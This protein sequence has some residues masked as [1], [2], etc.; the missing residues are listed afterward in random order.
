M[1]QRLPR[2]VTLAVC[3][4]ISLGCN[5]PATREGSKLAAAIGT[6]L[7]AGDAQQFGS[8]FADDA[9]LAA[10]EPTGTVLRGRKQIVAYYAANFP[11]SRMNLSLKQSELQVLGDG[12]AVQR[13]E[14]GGFIIRTADN[15]RIDTRG[16]YV[17][18]LNRRDDGSWALF[19]AIWGFQHPGSVGA[20]DDDGCKDCCCAT[21]S[22]CDCKA[23]E[24][25]T[26]PKER[27]IQVTKP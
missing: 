11:H 14:I 20:A 18:V 12:S 25:G 26:C 9:V 5:P 7:S 1:M 8:L 21:V 4:L 27:P 16:T 15:I 24:G 2:L 23:R 6:A 10:A 3:T 17:H 22:G 19:R 13:G